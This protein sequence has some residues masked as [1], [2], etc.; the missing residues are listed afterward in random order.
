MAR[1]R[2][3]VLSSPRLVRVD[4]LLVAAGAPSGRVQRADDAI[5]LFEID[6]AAGASLLADLK[7]VPFADA[8]LLRRWQEACPGSRILWV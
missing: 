8:G 5:E 4:A 3:I 7:D 1:A 6:A 2:I